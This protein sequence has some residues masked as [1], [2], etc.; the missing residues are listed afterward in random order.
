[1]YIGL[2]KV[3]KTKK[4]TKKDFKMR[5]K[6]AFNNSVMIKYFTLIIF[7]LI[8]SLCLNLTIGQKATSKENLPKNVFG[9][10]SVKN[11]F[12]TELPEKLNVDT[13]INSKKTGKIYVKYKIKPLKTYVKQTSISDKIMFNY[14]CFNNEVLLKIQF[15]KKTIFEKTISK[16]FFQ[17][18]IDDYKFL[19]EAVL[20]DF[21][22]E[23]Y[24]PKNS[25][26][27]FKINIS[28]PDSDLYQE[29]YLIVDL[30]GR[31]SYKLIPYPK[32][33]NE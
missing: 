9:V 1:M 2:E 25:K 24:N 32:D 29:L 5:N 17:N 13:I 8:Q 26:I 30:Q 21:A 11:I 4:I 6:D 33:I 27:Y 16:K 10:D 22:F 19:N 31:I 28:I 15:E 12:F 3:M 14:H 20:A 7:I 23:V 18:I